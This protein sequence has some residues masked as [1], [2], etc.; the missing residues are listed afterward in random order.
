MVAFRSETDS[1]GQVSVPADKL[2]TILDVQVDY[3]HTIDVY[4]QLHEGVL[5]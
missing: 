2:M 4:A 1:L 5:N 3:S